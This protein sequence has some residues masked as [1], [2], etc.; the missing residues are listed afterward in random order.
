MFCQLQNAPVLFRALYTRAESDMAQ[1]IVG[2]IGVCVC[3]WFSFAQ[4]ASRSSN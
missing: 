2:D 3:D 4:N 1:G